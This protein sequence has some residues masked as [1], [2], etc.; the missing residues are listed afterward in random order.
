[1]LDRVPRAFLSAALTVC[2]FGSA[3]VIGA[4]SPDNT[5]AAPGTAPAT[6][7]FV[8]AAEGIGAVDV[9]D[10]VSPSSRKLVESNLSFGMEDSLTTG[11][12]THWYDITLTGQTG[13]VAVP[14]PPGSA[15]FLSGVSY[16]VVVLDS[17]STP[18]AFGQLLPAILPDTIS[19]NTKIRLV[20]GAEALGAIDFYVNPT[21][22]VFSGS[23]P[24]VS[25]L[26]FPLNTSTNYS[27]T[28]IDATS[29]STEILVLPTGDTNQP[30]AYVDSTVTLTAGQALTAILVPNPSVM[31]KGML[32]FVRD[33]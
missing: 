17:G 16:D 10:S 27:A 30:D 25:D 1:M 9:Y 15:A 3:L 13:T 28:Y 2:T 26:A 14:P 12:G 11:A 18:S 31:G 4:C 33:H 29:G 21:G 5:P 19:T 22:T 20:H 8:H 7:R 32:V 24:V 23:S 6:V